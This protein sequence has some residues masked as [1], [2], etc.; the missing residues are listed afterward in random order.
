MKTIK[1]LVVM[2]FSCFSLAA[3]QTYAPILADSNRWTVKAWYEGC[4]TMT[5]HMDNDTLFNNIIYKK[6]YKSSFSNQPPLFA[7]KCLLREDTIQKKVYFRRVV[8]DSVSTDEHL[9]YDFGLNP[10]DSIYLH[11]PFLLYDYHPAGDEFGWYKL[12]SINSMQTLVGTRKR[13]F[14]T[15]TQPHQYGYINYLNWVESVGEVNVYNGGGSY[16]YYQTPIGGSELLCVFRNNIKVLFAGNFINTLD[17]TCY[18]NASSVQEVNGKS[19]YIYPNPFTNYINIE[20]S[21]ENLMNALFR[22]YNS[23]G[24]LLSSF[25]I[26]ENKIMLPEELPKGTYIVVINTNKAVYTRVI[27]K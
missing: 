15:R 17:T 10:G 6:L 14:F 16:L 4:T 5:L 20:L 26:K 24:K 13:Y 18:C 22:M 12:D 11:N 3:Q 7:L 1:F 9:M 21:N 25:L 23:Q 19:A 2:I 8:L 27:N